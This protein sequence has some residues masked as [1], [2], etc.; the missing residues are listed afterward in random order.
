MEKKN[1]R[2]AKSLV[3]D[4]I[5]MYHSLAKLKHKIIMV[6]M[7]VMPLCVWGSMYASLLINF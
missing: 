3:R 6:L 4:Q 2:V 7:S 5:F 1:F